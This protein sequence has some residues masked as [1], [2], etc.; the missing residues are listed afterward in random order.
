[1]ANSMVLT[2]DEGFA[3]FGTTGSYGDADEDSLLVK[4]DANGNM[5]WN[6]T[7]G[8]SGNEVGT[9]LVET[10]D[11]GFVLGGYTTSFG[12][13]DSDFWLVKTDEKGD[14]PEFP[15]Y[16]LLPLFLTLTLVVIIYTKK[17]AKNDYVKMRR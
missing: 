15:S 14:I 7:Y 8:D 17:L 16:T 13:G 10:N 1:M 3:L 12:D 11:G 5:Q 4:T 2:S 9:A 6:Q